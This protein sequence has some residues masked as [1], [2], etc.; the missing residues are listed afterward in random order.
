MVKATAPRPSDTQPAGGSPGRG[1]AWWPGGQRVVVLACCLLLAAIPF[2]TAPGD[3]IADTKF[4][5]VVNPSGFLSSALTLW[6]PQQFGGL[7][8]Q[9][10]G[11][12]F[13][14]G[15]FFKV[16]RLLS[17]E[18]WIVQRL[19]IGLLLIAAFAGTAR[20]AGRM[21]IGTQGTRAAAG[22]AY[23]MSPI[24]LS[25][26]GH[27]SG[28]FLPMAMLPWI[29]VPLADMRPWLDDTRPERPGARARAVARSAVAVAL[30]SGMNAA[31]AIAVLVPVLIYI[32]TRRG[33]GPRIRMLAWWFP[34][35]G[36]VTFS[37]SVPLLLLSRYGVSVVPY[38]ESA[39]V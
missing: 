29:L 32:L 21:G 33:A 11:Y 4:E 1:A 12:L 24:A 17:V 7:L 35:V 18:G 8:N 31:S 30:C 3:I 9:A 38:T 2:A 28:E 22:L 15:P 6:D 37:W 36:L 16:L 25:I 34:A 26:V 14:M 13:P 20:L 5:L 39:Q 23:A 19:W 10:V 27:M